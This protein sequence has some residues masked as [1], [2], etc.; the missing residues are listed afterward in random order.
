MSNWNL[1]LGTSGPKST[2]NRIHI[3]PTSEL[4]PSPPDNF[5]SKLEEIP[6]EYGLDQA[7]PSPFNPTTTIK[8]QLPVDCKVTMK[9]HNMLGQVVAVLID[10][11]QSAG[12]KSVVW[13]A[14][15]MASG[16]YI[17]RLDAVNTNDPKKSYTDVKKITFIK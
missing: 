4:P 7:Y 15:N 9:V 2:T 12:Y 10:E 8:Y 5:G 14:S 6:T 3:I 13:N 16:V 17:Y 11:Y 1:A